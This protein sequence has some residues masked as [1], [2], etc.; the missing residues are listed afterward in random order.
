MRQKQNSERVEY[1]TI[2]GQWSPH[3]AFYCAYY[4]AYLTEQQAKQHHC[5]SKHGKG[6]CVKLCD[7]ERKGVRV[8][9][10]QRMQSVLDKILHKLTNIDMNISRLLKQL[11]KMQDRS[12]N[13]DMMDDGK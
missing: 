10:E 6:I 5:F 3:P 12:D 4:K 13:I 1:R 9:N 2:T 7:T 11:E 8:T